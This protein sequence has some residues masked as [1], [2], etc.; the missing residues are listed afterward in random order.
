MNTLHNQQK[1]NISVKRKKKDL[2]DGDGVQKHVML[3][4]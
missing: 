2:Y 3:E 1:F 4:K